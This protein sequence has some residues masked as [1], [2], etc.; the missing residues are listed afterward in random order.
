[1]GP[2]YILAYPLIT[3]YPSFWLSFH[4]AIPFFQV[5]RHL[6]VEMCVRYLEG[7]PAYPTASMYGIF[8]YIWLMFM[9]NVGEYT[10]HGW[11]GYSNEPP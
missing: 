10:I 3:M 4:G 5:F 1:M 11:Y 9:V 2:G 7:F 8:T 6:G